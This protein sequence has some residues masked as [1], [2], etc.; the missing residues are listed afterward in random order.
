M[1]GRLN[2]LV[3]RVFHDAVGQGEQINVERVHEA[4]QKQPVVVRGN[5]RPLHFTEKSLDPGLIVPDLDDL[6]IRLVSLRWRLFDLTSRVYKMPADDRPDA[7]VVDDLRAGKHLS[8][9]IH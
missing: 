8:P 3:S 4:Y 2:I 7:G 1:P 6:E 9:V 5:D